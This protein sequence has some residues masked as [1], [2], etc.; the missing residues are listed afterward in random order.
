MRL[1][2]RSKVI[3][4]SHKDRG[5][6]L[7]AGRKPAGAYW[8]ESASG[9]F[10]TSSYY[11]KELPAWVREFNGRQRAASFVGQKWSRL[12]D[13]SAY[14]W[15]DVAAGE[16]SLTGEKT[17]TFDHTIHPSPVE[18]FET[19]IPTP[20][21]NQLL[22]EF[23]LAALEGEQ[24][25][26]GPQPDLLCISYSSVDVA[27]HRFGP[28]S[29]EVQDITL[30]LDRQLAELF[31][32]LDKK[33]GL[34]HVA[35]VLTADHGVAPTPEF[36]AAQGFDGQ[37]VEEAPLMRE[38]QARLNERFGEAKFLLAPRTL[39]ELYFDHEILRQRQVAAEDLA[40]VIREWALSTGK[41][42]AAFSRGQLLDGRAP[43]LLGQRVLAGYHAERSGDM[44][45]IYKPY[46]IPTGAKSGTTHGSP[47]AFDTRVPVLFYG[48]G[49]KR[50]R[51][52]D[53]FAI[54]DVVPTLCAALRLS[55]PPGSVGRPLVK[56]LADSK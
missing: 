56:I 10:I 41:F 35:I 17:P 21:G 24:L 15:P 2:F 53:P 5:A 12:L 7:P 29:Q 11:M 27:G 38:L 13:A 37:R 28:Y 54:T 46:H 51:Y 8:F 45:L 1:R 18:G 4:L 47:Y 14:H 31:A 43:G 40:G 30:R 3:G 23:A 33:V 20:F 52:A 9:H 50:G 34:Q 22:T 42:Q 48:A 36:A 25:G 19:I 16:G 32:Q 26:A 55:E 6:I 49:F 39:D 44:M